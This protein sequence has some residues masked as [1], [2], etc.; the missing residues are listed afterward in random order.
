MI[1]A[2]LMML[3]GFCIVTASFADQKEAETF[4]DSLSADIKQTIKNSS[5]AEQTKKQEI[6]KIVTNAFDFKSATKF[7]LGTHWSD[8]TKEQRMQFYNIYR[9]YLIGIYA[10]NIPTDSD[11]AK[12]F[13][14]KK[15]STTQ[16]DSLSDAFIVTSNIIMF[17]PK[18]IS[19][20]SIK[21]EFIIRNSKEENTY[22]VFDVVVEGISFTQAQ[23]MEFDSTIQ[24][25]GFDY[26][27]KSLQSK[28]S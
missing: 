20:K 13:D 24:S 18:A 1:K 7:V 2:F 11:S 23:R 14:I 5:S 19:P 26:L 28:R 17:D 12:V 25:K 27:I 3:F 22:K 6:I 8:I 10:K 9:E 4:F 15:V 16:H 21:F